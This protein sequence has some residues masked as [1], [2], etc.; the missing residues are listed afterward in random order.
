[1][2]R[3]GDQAGSLYSAQRTD[4]AATG[5]GS[6]NKAVS[7]CK[8]HMAKGE[9]LHPEFEADICDRKIDLTYR[10][11]GESKVKGQAFLGDKYQ[12]FVDSLGNPDSFAIFLRKEGVLSDSQIDFLKLLEEKK[13]KARKLVE[14]LA[15]RFDYLSST[16]ER[17]NMR[18]Q[19]A[20]CLSYSGNEHSADFLGKINR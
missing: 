6:K 7:P 8:S 3:V 13:E 9:V 16:N 5:E 19:M 14:M 4:G 1:M 12:E 10:G 11:L 2:Q 15:L 18:R 17:L 20:V